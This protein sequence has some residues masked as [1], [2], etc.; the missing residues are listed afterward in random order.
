MERRKESE[1]HC[2]TCYPGPLPIQ[3]LFSPFSLQEEPE[4]LFWKATGPI[5]NTYCPIPY[6]ISSVQGDLSRNLLSLIAVKTIFPDK[7]RDLAGTC[8]FHFLSPF[9]LP[10]MILSAGGGRAA[11]LQVKD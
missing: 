4:I 5:E 11:I 10:Q 2:S 3:Y 1:G 6:M 9:F 7:Q 8:L